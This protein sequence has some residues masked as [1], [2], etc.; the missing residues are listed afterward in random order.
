MIPQRA[1]TSAGMADPFD[2]DGAKAR[3]TQRGDTRR[4]A[5]EAAD[6]DLRFVMGDARGRRFVWSLLE[7][8]GVFRSVFSTTALTMA[9]AEGGRN[10]GLKL[11][12]RL[13]RVTPAE[14]RTAQEE[15]TVVHS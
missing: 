9:H 1:F 15:S 6:K 14:Y 7:D 10:Q 12:N 13:L 11:L 3:D 5:N 4:A 2:I 8:A